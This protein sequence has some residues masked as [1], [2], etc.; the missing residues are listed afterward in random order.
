MVAKNVN[1][2]REL[3]TRGSKGMPYDPRMIHG[4]RT[5]ATRWTAHGSIAKRLSGTPGRNR[6]RQLHRQVPYHPTTGAEQCHVGRPGGSRG[7]R[8]G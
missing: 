7:T 4:R 6:V 1:H 8:A 2:E 3:S 5:L